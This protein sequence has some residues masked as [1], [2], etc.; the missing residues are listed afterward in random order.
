MT[1]PDRA[2]VAIDSMQV[3]VLATV[4]D[5]ER[6]SVAARGTDTWL[7]TAGAVC[8]VAP[9]NAQQYV[10]EITGYILWGVLALFTI[11]MLIGIGAILAGRIF[12]MPHASKAGVVSI[13]IIFVAGIG[14]L[15][16]PGMVNGFMG[17][18]CI[19]A[20]PAASPAVSSVH[21]LASVDGV[22]DVAAAV[23]AETAQPIAVSMLA[24]GPLGPPVA[25]TGL[26]AL[27]EDGGLA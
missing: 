10:D 18:G 27:T 16:L 9:G 19:T 26:A 15:V 21:R 20:S 24:P 12:G 4:A 3:S 1:P 8:P 7:V 22:G 5:P 6:V 11:G 17:T 2:T 23:H 14:Y 13:V 25:W